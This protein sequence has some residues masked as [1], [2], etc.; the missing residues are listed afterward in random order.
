MLGD[1]TFDLRYAM[2]GFRS[3]PGFA[4]TAIVSLALGIGANTAIFSLIDAVLLK[5]LPVSHPEQLVQVT[6]DP[7]HYIFT[8]PM[9][10]Q[11]RDRQDVFSGVFAWQSASFNLTSGGEQHNVRASWAGGDYFSALGVRTVLGRTFSRDDDHRGCAGMAVLSYDFWQR[12]YGG[13]ADAINRT[14]SLDNHP[15]QILGVIEPGFSG[16]D[17]GRAV[18]VYV[19]VC[20]EKIIRGNFSSLDQRSNWWLRIM[21]R[22]KP[23]VTAAQVA[24]RLKTIAPGIMADTLPANFDALSTKVFLGRTLQAVPAGN[25]FSFLRRDYRTAL[26]TLM[27]VVA[28]VLLIACANVA[29][30]LLARAT[31]RQ[32]EIAVR[33]A[34]GAGR[35]RLVRQLLTESV[36]LSG[37][38]AGLGAVFAFWGTQTIV[39]MLSSSRQQVFL[40]LTIDL[41]VLG[42]TI[43][44]AVGT[45][46][47][48]GLAPAWR[49]TR[50]SP[51]A[52]IKEGSRSATQGRASF[53]LGKA[54]VMAQVALSLVLITGA[55][56]LVGTFRKLTTMNAGFERDHVLLMTADVRNTEVPAA[57]RAQLYRDILDR[58]RTLPGVRSAGTSNMVPISGA[59]SK[60]DIYVDGFMPKD[61]DD[62]TVYINQVSSGF[63]E[64]MGTKLVA[65]RD[66]NEHDTLTSPKVAIINESVARKFFGGKN[67][68]GQTYRTDKEG[69]E[70]AVEIVGVVEDAKYANLREQNSWTV[71]QAVSQQEFAFPFSNFE[72]RGA[73]SGADLIPTVRSAMVDLNKA[74]VTSFTPMTTQVEESLTRERL[75]ATLSAFFGGLALLLAAIGLYGVMSYRVA[76]R[77][78]EIGIR[79]ALGAEQARV[80]RMVLREVALVI[81]IGLTVGVGAAIASTKLIATFLYGVQ[82]RDATTLIGSAALL[83]SIAVLAGYLPARRASRLDPMVAL[84]EE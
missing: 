11:V 46:L 62:T 14:I 58:L 59:W 1:L 27:A 24:A 8:N 47:L 67:P 60:N 81:G 36:L 33:L 83:A 57:R 39:A 40:D 64:T 3:S 56:L 72:I 19:P 51:Q 41:R 26:L 9:W 49:G 44:I 78:N 22:P 23:G 52:T 82:P 55:G 32:R 80:M 84:R 18:D 35:A 12:A 68:I 69:K 50:V 63:F 76:Q 73:T 7:E 20:S 15:F 37:A 6:M 75:L 65:G 34:L 53:G 31:L 13:S 54:L 30:L 43:A 77:K 5:T 45:G 17:V 61:E 2:R 21:A 74:V 38:G 25:G 42:F 10:E 71:Y 4:L 29:N 48:F 70:P 66:F 28:L 16:V 79:M